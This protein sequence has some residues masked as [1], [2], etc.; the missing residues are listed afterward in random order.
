MIK[1]VNTR[2]FGDREGK[3]R[4]KFRCE[5]DGDL[6]LH[7]NHE[8][9]KLLARRIKAT[10]REGHHLPTGP[11]FGTRNGS[12]APPVDRGRGTG[13]GRR[14]YRGRG[15]SRGGSTSIPLDR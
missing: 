3:L 4:S 8:G 6:R 15:T 14:N 1:F 11:R 13:R 5:N 2:V 9:I 10:L 7:V 12:E